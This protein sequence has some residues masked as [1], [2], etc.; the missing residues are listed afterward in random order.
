MS[1]NRI[2]KCVAILLAQGFEEAEAIIVIDLLRRLDITVE[3]LA[4][5]ESLELLSYHDIRIF[6]DAL[7][8][9]RAND[10]YDA[11]VIPGG[12]EGTVNLATNPR[13][14]EFIRRHDTAGKLVCPLCSAAARVL[15][16][17]GL[18]NGPLCLFWRPLSA[19]GPG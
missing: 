1:I 3:K 10:L 9:H 6:A 15:G 19:G 11:V 2:G 17:N 8:S 4:C 7:L 18:L 14:A 16:G 13:V 5:Q 12:P